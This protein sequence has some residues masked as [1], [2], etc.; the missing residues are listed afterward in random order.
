[1]RGR[2]DRRR[3]VERA[4]DT[5]LGEIEHEGREVA[6]VD[7]LQLAL[8]RRG[9]GDVSAAG[10]PL[11]PPRQ[12]EDVVVRADDAACP[13]ARPGARPN[14]IERALGERLLLPVILALGPR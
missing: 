1:E 11:A 3:A 13:D 2:P 5:A 6:R 14:R 12:P 7:Q 10:D 4:G 9:S 8:R